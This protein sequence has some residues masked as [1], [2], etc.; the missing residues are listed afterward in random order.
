[1]PRLPRKRVDPRQSQPIAYVVD[2]SGAP[3]EHTWTTLDGK[4]LHTKIGI[5]W[6]ETNLPDEV[7][8]IHRVWMSDETYGDAYPWRR[9][10]PRP[11][12]LSRFQKEASSGQLSA[13]FK[14]T[15]WGRFACDNHC[16][17]PGRH[18]K[19]AN[20]TESKKDERGGMSSKE[21]SRHQRRLKRQQ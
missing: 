21:W 19:E 10:D 14:L 11:T 12:H 13:S 3:V 5:Y 1:M 20:R 6:M 9:G 4:K 15:E 2:S 16:K 8:G 17:C 7:R 18:V